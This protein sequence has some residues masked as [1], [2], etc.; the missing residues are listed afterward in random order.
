M[1]DGQGKLT[2]HS[3]I[4]IKFVKLNK[5]TKI[6]FFEIKFQKMLTNFHQTFLLAF[7]KYL[8]QCQSRSDSCLIQ[9]STFVYP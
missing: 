9:G 5:I 8:Y 2:L 6:Y 1:D 7:Q 4:Y 3:N